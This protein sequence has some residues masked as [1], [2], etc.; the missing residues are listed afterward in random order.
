MMPA[1]DYYRVLNISLSATTDE[2]KKAFRKL[3]LQ[4]HPDKNNN[5]QLAEEKFVEIQEAYHILSDKRKR[6]EYNYLKYTQN[7]QWIYKPIAQSPDD[8]IRLGKKLSEETERADPFRIDRDLLFFEITDLFSAHNLAVLSQANDTAA[9]RAIFRY[10]ITTLHLLPFS[11]Q[12][13]IAEK[14]TM[15]TKD[16]TVSKKE[17]QQFISHAKQYA[18]W[19]RYKVYIALTA[20]VLFCIVVFFSV[21]K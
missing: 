1:K 13:V 8:I 2:I 9:N 7:P 20:A 5:T 3:A 19:N 14:L 16:N 11:M 18:Y 4:Y 17:L 6:A 15:L 12:T 21:R 10:I